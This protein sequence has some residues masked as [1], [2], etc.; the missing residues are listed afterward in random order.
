LTKA[1]PPHVPDPSPQPIHDAGVGFRRSTLRCLPPRPLVGAGGEEAVATTDLTRS[2]HV[3]PVH[4]PAREDHMTQ[5][6]SRPRQCWDCREELLLLA[7][8]RAHRPTF[9]GYRHPRSSSS[10]RLHRTSTGETKIHYHRAAHAAS[11]ECPANRVTPS[12]PLITERSSRR[13]PA[14]RRVERA[15]G[16]TDRSALHRPRL[17]VAMVIDN[18]QHRRGRGSSVPTDKAMR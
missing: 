12:V 4:R 2:I 8:S 5:S 1:T 15:L 7:Q 14:F 13:R 6:L 16:Q 10:V 11:A 17:H 9:V 3:A 18:G